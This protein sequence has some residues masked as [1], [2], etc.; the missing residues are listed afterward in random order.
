MLNPDLRTSQTRG[1]ASVLAVVLSVF[2][3]VAVSAADLHLHP[4]FTDH[5]VIQQNQQVPVW[6]TTKPRQTVAVEFA[7]QSVSAVSDEA[8]KWMAYLKPI[9]ANAA[10]QD[11]RVHCGDESVTVADLLVGE[12]WLCSGQSNMAAPVR[13]STDYA[14]I[15]AEI[16]AK[17]SFSTL[18]LFRV[19]VKG[20]DEPLDRV[21]AQWSKVDEATASAFSAAAFYFGRALNRDRNVPV[22][23]I[24]SANGGTNAYSWINSATYNSDPVAEVTRIH[25]DAIVRNG[26]KS[27]EKFETQKKAWAAK[28]RAA[29]I[30]KKPVQGQAPREPL[31]RD[32]VKRPS[33]HYNAMIA[34][35][36]PY[37][38]AGAIW[39]QGEANSRPPFC[40]QYKDL[41]LALVEDWRADWYTASGLSTDQSRDDFPFY[42]V[43]LPNYANGHPEGWPIIR[44]QMLCFWQEGKNTGMVTTIDVGD[45][46]DIHPRN[47]MPVGQRLALFARGNEY[48]EEIVYSG[49][50][51]NSVKI[52]G[53]RATVSFDHIGSGLVS[54]DGKPL[55]HFQVAGNDLSFVDADAA[56][57]NN[58]VV[59][60]SP[61]VASIKHVRYAW[62][63]NP[64]NPNLVNQEGLVASPFR[65]D[66]TQLAIE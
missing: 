48:G 21:N 58:S 61:Q 41:M 3:C 26:D 9:A 31:H 10:G 8:G 5:G 18:R 43:Q 23:L 34:P 62:S 42:L 60:S 17:D 12:V 15:Q 54:L 6:G 37:A 33:G 38:I 29:K 63:N 50:V 46:K 56:I 4:L 40:S 49:P 65:S 55:R 7:G 20:S 19:P 27:L 45:P 2:S 44:E 32:H 57:E 30:A 22:G 14:T 28:Q 39:Y 66:D 16:A 25:W 53:N 24:Q 47:K 51:F 11:L 35:L 1:L 13:N 36:Q 64:E 52:D 59:V